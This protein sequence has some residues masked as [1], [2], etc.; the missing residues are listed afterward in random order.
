[1]AAIRWIYTHMFL[2]YLMTCLP[3]VWVAVY[4]FSDHKTSTEKLNYKKMDKIYATINVNHAGSNREDDTFLSDWSLQDGNSERFSVANA[5]E[6]GLDIGR[7]ELEQY[8]QFVKMDT[9][10]PRRTTI[11]GY[12]YRV[13]LIGNRPTTQ[14]LFVRIEEHYQ[15]RSTK[16][17]STFVI[18]SDGYGLSLCPYRDMFNG[19][20][21]AW[22]PHIVS[23]QRRAITV[24]LQFV[25]FRA[26]T[27]VCVQSIKY[28]ICY[29]ASCRTS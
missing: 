10:A 13:E 22:C 8:R 24:V 18:T 2:C 1:M 23:G 15:N 6:V 29:M 26:F 3:F 17:G 19:T 12:S 4:V 5:S 7:T 20:Y 28:V 27:I 11:L 16:G 14:G 21:I 25:D 9:R